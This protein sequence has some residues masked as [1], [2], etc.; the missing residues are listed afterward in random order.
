MDVD[1]FLC[2]KCY[3]KA[4]QKFMIYLLI[5]LLLMILHGNTPRLN[6]KSK[7]FAD[8]YLALNGT[9]ELKS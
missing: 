7:E 9:F 5:G 1:L 8:D 3:K 2:K 6:F 4:K